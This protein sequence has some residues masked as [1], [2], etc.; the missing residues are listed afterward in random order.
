MIHAIDA[1]T[2]TDVQAVAQ[3]LFVPEGLTEVVWH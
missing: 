1:I 3:D 2:A